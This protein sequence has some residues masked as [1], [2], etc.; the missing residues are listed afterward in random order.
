MKTKQRKQDAFTA[1]IW[2][3]LI[4]ASK[5]IPDRFFDPW[6]IHILT[7]LLIHDFTSISVYSRIPFLKKFSCKTVFFSIHNS[8]VQSIFQLFLI[9]NSAGKVR[10]CAISIFSSWIHEWAIIQ[11]LNMISG[12][13]NYIRF[14]LA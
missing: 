9:Q 11:V 2:L 3:F 1:Q 13:T 7:F 8:I 14:S 6:Q 12:H 10:M 5:S 4:F